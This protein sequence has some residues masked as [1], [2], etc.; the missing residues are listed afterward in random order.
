MLQIN[1]AQVFNKKEGND[2]MTMWVKKDLQRASNRIRATSNNISK[3]PMKLKFPKRILIEMFRLLT[4]SETKLK[5]KKI[6][7]SENKMNE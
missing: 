2:Q 7:L 6:K 5:R 4:L 1:K 3:C